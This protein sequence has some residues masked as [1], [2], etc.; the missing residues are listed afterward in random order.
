[1]TTAK[2]MLLRHAEKPDANG[3]RGVAMTGSED[4]RSLTVRGWQRAGALIALFGPE[5]P[6]H[7]APLLP[8]PTTIFAS[9]PTA[10]SARS[11]H[12]IEPLAQRLSIDIDLSYGDAEE[13]ALAARVVAGNGIVL[14]SWKHDGLPKLGNAI[15][16]NA[17]TCPQVWPKDRFDLVW[18][19]DRPID[20]AAW[21]FAQIPQL[22]LRGDRGEPIA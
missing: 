11:F 13:A 3:T 16:G 2:I 20:G 7:T 15:V 22:L 6:R 10:N 9:R 21:R 18:V 8:T 17:T 19:F 12:T 5:L 14:I 4:R 1:L